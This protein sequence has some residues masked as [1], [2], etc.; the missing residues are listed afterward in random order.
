MQASNL[1]NAIVLLLPLAV[2]AFSC[3]TATEKP[4]A[5]PVFN[6]VPAAQSGISFSNNVEENAGKNNY[7]NFAYVY[8]GA[9]VA[10]G[11][12]NNDGLP[13]VYLTANE[14]PNKLYLNLG[15]MKFKDITSSAGV[16]GGQGWDNG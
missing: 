3:N 7:E 15:G 12:I 1:R 8:N 4:A 10:I 9:G 16:D 2:L 13:D 5:K 6:K 14:L 11:D